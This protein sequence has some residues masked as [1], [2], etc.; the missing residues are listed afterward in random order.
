[1]KKLQF[2]LVVLSVML[3]A[4]G[5]VA[6]VQN[7]QIKRVPPSPSTGFYCGSSGYV[8]APGYH[9]VVRPTS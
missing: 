9:P 6:Q 4:L 2:C 7:G 8:E 3:L 5:A 1:M